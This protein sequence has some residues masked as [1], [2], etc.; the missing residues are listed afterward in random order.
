MAQQQLLQKHQQQQQQFTTTTSTTTTTASTA[1]SCMIQIVK[2]SW[3]EACWK[4]QR[5]VDCSTGS[6]HDLLTTTTTTNRVVEEKVDGVDAATAHRRPT[7]LSLE[8][9]LHQQLLLCNNSTTTSLLNN[10]IDNSWLFSGCHICLV[11]FNKTEAENGDNDDDDDDL[12]GHVLYQQLTRLIRR[13]MGTIYWES[14]CNMNVITHMIAN[15]R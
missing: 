15:N 11:G 7:T 4:E 6:E 8:E 12:D 14:S 13:C 1:H 5:L 9:A 3:I 10:R 2:P